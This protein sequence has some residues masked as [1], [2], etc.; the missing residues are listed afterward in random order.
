MAKL[1]QKS[2]ECWETQ[3][4]EGGTGMERNGK[5]VYEK[6]GRSNNDRKERIEKGRKKLA[7]LESSNCMELCCFL[8]H[9]P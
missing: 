3:D 7:H 5:G 2:W 8:V 1:K 6:E 9:F 4:K